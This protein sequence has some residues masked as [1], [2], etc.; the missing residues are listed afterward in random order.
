MQSLTICCLFIPIGRKR[1]ME[2][3]T[4]I[5]HIQEKGRLELL[6]SRFSHSSTSR[7]GLNARLGHAATEG[8]RYSTNIDSIH[9]KEPKLD[10]CG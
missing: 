10:G 3:F 6:A 1:I 4:M 7:H 9:S 5:R 8:V 2:T